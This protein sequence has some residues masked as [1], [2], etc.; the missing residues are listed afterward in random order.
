MFSMCIQ[1]RG[2]LV[3][4]P[5]HIL[6]FKLMGLDRKYNT[7]PSTDPTNEVVAN[8]LLESQRWLTSNSRDILD[9]SDEILHVKY[10][11]VYTVG[12]QQS[13][14]G[15]PDRWIIV[16][17][18][19][20]LVKKHAGAIHH[21]HPDG[22]EVVD[23]HS[24]GYP[25]IRILS[26]DAGAALIKLVAEDI[27]NGALDHCS[28]DLFPLELRSS[29]LSYIA[30]LQVS[31]QD[32]HILEEYCRNSDAWNTLLIVRGLLAH[33]I[34]QFV[35][36]EK[37]WRVDYGPDFSRSM[38][39]VPYRAK[40][41]PSLRAEFSHP[42][43][44]ILLTCLS[45]YWQ[46]LSQSQLEQCFD[47]LLKQDN[48]SMEYRKW[49]VHEQMVPEQLTHLGGIHLR[50]L[51]QRTELHNVFHRNHAVIDF[52]LSQIVFPRDAKEFPSKMATSGWDLAETKGHVTTGFSGTND[53][54]YLLPT[55]IHH[56]DPLSQSSTNAK[57]LMY[58]LR[59]ENDFYHCV[60]QSGMR[61]SEQSLLHLLGEQNPEIRVLL[62][63]GAQILK[64]SNEEVAMEW[65]K[66]NK[67][68]QVLAV[69]FFGSDDEPYVRTRNGMIE[70][71]VSSPFRQQP[72]KC[73]LY[74]DDAHTRGTDFKLPSGT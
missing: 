69:V 5:D 1:A 6:S 44:A 65:L 3:V 72:D 33:G 68:P 60:L 43:V 35:L 31:S 64:L 27:W 46:G 50:D 22:F 59:P 21:S 71:L 37:R 34:L 42:D 17:Q 26:D 9:E 15:S 57:V 70:G 53:G 25:R 41:V 2:V 19:L 11:L 16:Q 63:V 18:V 29:V 32:N 13:V 38:M 20:A 7:D 12:Q 30:S 14:H 48:P 51:D 40:D 39:A 49:V 36:K 8:W 61:N 74:L 67:N 56:A 28:F 54:R 10:Q 23:D 55:S 47:L 66:L 24:G 45:Y 58:L 52:F 62:D 73:L 4:Q